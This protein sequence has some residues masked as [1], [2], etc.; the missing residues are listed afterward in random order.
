MNENS[1]FLAPTTIEEIEDIIQNFKLNKALGPNSIPIRILKDQKEEIA[2][3]LN[4]LINTCFN[5]GLF[6]DLLKIAKAIPIFKNKGNSQDCSNYRPISL[7]SNLH[8]IIEKLLYQQ[9]YAFLNEHNCLYKHQFGFRNH[10]STNHALISITKYIRKALD[11]GEFA[12]G[13]FLDFQKAFD[14]VNHEILLSKLEHYGIR[15]V[16]LNPL[17]SYLNKKQKL[18][19]IYQQFS[20]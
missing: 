6:P 16:P 13:V 5:L 9:L 15:G 19:Y 7:L 2:K 14:T 4:D 12:C 17:R 18:I 3:P 11:N 10:H 8:K 1:F 20:I